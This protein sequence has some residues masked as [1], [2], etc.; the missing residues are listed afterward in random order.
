M[1][2]LLVVYD[3]PNDKTRRRVGEILE[4]FGTRVNRSVFECQVK[5]ASHREKLQ[6]ALSRELDPRADSL[7]VYTICANC[8]ASSVALGK[9]PEPFE[10]DAVYFF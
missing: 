9:E 2:S 7:R 6:E 8:M 1:I 5:N 4:G 3:I 10:R